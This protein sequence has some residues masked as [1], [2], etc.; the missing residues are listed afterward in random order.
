MLDNHLHLLV[1]LD[2]ET[3]K[4]WSDEEVI[5]RLGPALPAA[6]QDAAGRWKRRTIGSKAICSIAA[7]IKRCRLRERLGGLSVGS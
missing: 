2:P 6:R 4:M 3:V 1:R 5:R 7:W